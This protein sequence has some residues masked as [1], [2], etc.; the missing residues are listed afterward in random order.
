MELRPLNLNDKSVFERYLKKQSHVLSTYSFANT[1]VWR[2]LFELTWALINEKFCL[3]FKNE[4]GCFM[5]MPPLGGL[6][7]ETLETVFEIMEGINH[8]REISRIENIEE[9]DLETFRK[10]GLRTYEKAREYIVDRQ[11]MVSLS[12]EKFRHKRS[13]RNFFQKNFGGMVRDYA[14]QDKQE[15]L[16]LYEEWARERMSKKDDP[17]YQAMLQDSQKVFREMIDGVRDLGVLAKVVECDGRIR[18]FTSGFPLNKEV[19]CINF[20]VADL[21]LKGIAQFVFSEFAKTLSPYPEINIM[22]DSGIETIRQTKVSYRP[23]KMVPSYTA[24]TRE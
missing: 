16:R 23:V 19:F 3:F 15:V 17:I 14:D 13:L 22:D 20:E 18:A 11:E 6:D 1:F 7:K 12:G 2:A 8:N 4:V 9:K 24:L 21:K 5:N 10:M